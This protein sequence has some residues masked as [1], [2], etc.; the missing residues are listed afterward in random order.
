F[1]QR[2]TEMSCWHG[3]PSGCNRPCR[4]LAVMAV[5]ALLISHE[6]FVQ[7]MPRD[8]RGT[9]VIR[10]AGSD[11]EEYESVFWSSEKWF[12]EVKVRDRE[13]ERLIFVGDYEL[14]EQAAKAA[15][16]AQLA[17]DQMYPPADGQRCWS[18]NLPKETI[19]E[20]EVDTAAAILQGKRPPAKPE[21]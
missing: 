1:V 9:R 11:P 18:R 7:Q 6:A 12:W 20:D 16:C 10:R 4:Q 5:A 3:Q 19:Y 21:E 17:L 14:A 15:D 8:W 2:M 13:S